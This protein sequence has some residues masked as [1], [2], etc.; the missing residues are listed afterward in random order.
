MLGKAGLATSV[1]LMASGLAHADSTI[2]LTAAPTT[3]TLPDGQT[4]PMWGLLCGSFTGS[5]FTYSAGTDGT[6]TGT[7][8]TT[9][10]GTAHTG[11]SWQP[12]RITVPAGKLSITLRNKLHSPVPTSLVIVGQVGGGLGGTPTTTPSPAHSVQGTT[13]PGTLGGTDVGAGDAVNVP[14]LQAARVQSFGTEVPSGGSNTL[15]WNNLRAGTYLIESGTHPSIQGPMG[16]YGV[17][18]VTDATYPGVTFDKDVALLLSEIDPAQNAAVDT[19]VRTPGFSETKVW[20]ARSGEC[21]DPASSTLNTCYPPAVNY[22]PRYYLINGVSFDRTR[23]AGSTIAGPGATAT[24]GNVLLRFVN[25]GL[26]MHVPSVVGA[27]MSLYAEDGNLLPGTPKIQD[28]V[29]LAAGKTYD[30]TIQP[31][32]TGTTYDSAAYAV[33]DRQLSLSTNNMRDGGMQAYISA[34]GGAPAAGVA[35]TASALDKTY[36][37]VAGRALS[38]T[39]PS[40]G[41]LGGS[42][43]ASGVSLVDSTLSPAD[44]SLSLQANGTFTYTPPAVPASCSGSFSYTV[45]GN[46]ALTKTA[47]ITECDATVQGPGCSLGGQP[48][49]AN[50]AYNNNIASRLQ[51]RAPGV[52]E[53]DTDPTGLPLCATKVGATACST[54]PQTFA[55]TNGAVTLNPDG[56]FVLTPT[57]VP[58]SGPSTVTFQYQAMNSQNRASGVATATVTFN[59]GNSIAFAVRDAKTGLAIHDYRWIIEEDRTFWIEPKCQINSTDPAVRP[60]TCPPLPVE[61]LGY[62]F[63]TANMPVVATGCLGAVSCESG[64]AIDGTAVACDVGD[65][66]CRKDASQ[67]VATLPSEVALDPNKRYYISILPGD[68]VNPVIGGAGGPDDNGKPFSIAAAC[69][70]YVEQALDASLTGSSPWTPGGANAMCGH[71]MG[72][73]QISA[74]QAGQISINLQQTP[75][76]TAKISVFVFEDDNPLNGE[77]DAGGGVDVLAPNEPGLGGFEVKLFDQA[78]GLGDATGQITY[79][80]FNMPVSNSLAGMPDPLHG[81]Q[82]ACPITKRADALVGMIPTCPHFEVDGVTESPL[83]GQALIANLYPGLYEVVAT[84]ASDRIARGEEW[85]QSN[86]LDGGKPHEAFIK[87][88]E[89]SYFQEFGPGG[90]HISIG[91]TNPKLITD[92]RSNTAGT[93]LCDPKPR[94]G[95]LTCD[96]TLKGSVTNARMSRTPDQRIYSSKSYD[97][98]S[99]TQCYVG[100]GAPDEPDFAFAKCNDDGTFEMDHLPSGDFKLTVFDQW[101]DLMLDGLVSP[102]TVASGTTVKEFPVTQWRTNLYTRTFLD[103]DGDGV[104]TRDADGNDSELGLPLVATNIRYRDGSFGF[105]N[106]TDLNG[107]A[108]FNEVFPFMNWL[109]VEAD[110]TRYKP[111]SAHVVYDTGGPADGAGGGTSAIAAGLANTIETNSLPSNLRVPGARYCASADCPAGDTAGGSSGRVDPAGITTEAW[112]GLLGQNSFIE[113]GMKPFQAGENGGIKGHVI[114]ASTRP[115]DD[116]AL[117]LQLSWEPGVPRVKL[118]LYQEGTAPDGTRTLKLVDTTTSSSWDDWAQ[119]FRSDGMPNMNCPGQAADSPFFETL[120]DS[121]QYLDPSIPKKDLPNHSQYKCYDGWSQLNQ[122]QPA[123]Y[124]GMYKFPSVTGISLVAETAG[125]PSGTNCSICVDNPSGDGTK[126]LPAGKYVVEVVLPEGF[127]LVKEEDK[128]ILLGDVYIA[129]VTQQFAGLGNIFIMPDQAAVN[130]YYNASNPGGINLTTNLGATARHEGDTGSVESFWPCV[131]AE[132]V[133]PDLNSLF[134]GAGQAAPFAGATR[135][136]CDRKEVILEDQAAVLAKFYVFTPTHIAGHFTGTITDDFASEF[137]PFSPQF[138][139]K[140]GPPNLPVGIRDFAG[141]EVARVVSD[142]W[143]L[144]NGLNYSSYAV[145]PPNPTGY[146][147]T[148]MIACMNDPGPIPVTNAQGQML[149]ASGAVVTDRSLAKMITDPSYNP[150]YS[151]FCYETPFMPGFT[152]YMDT[153]VIPTMAFADGY[154]LPDSEYPDATPAILRVDAEG[155]IGPWVGLAGPVASVTLGA[156]GSYTTVPNVTFTPTDSHGSGAAATALLG[157]GAVTV[158]SPNGTYRGIATP[159]VTF[160]LPGCAI[161]GTT[162]VRATGTATMSGGGITSNTRHVTGI[163][164]TNPGRGYTTAPGITFSTGPATAVASLGVSFVNLTSGGSGYDAVPAVTFSTGSATATA[165]LGTLTASG[166]LTITALGDKVVQNPAFSGPNS[167]TAPYNQKTIVRHYVFG[168][169]GPSSA[170]TIGGVNAPITSWSDTSITVTV[171]TTGVPSCSANGPLQRTGVGTNTYA[172]QCGELVITAAN[173]KKSID[174]VTVTLGGKPPTYVT[175]QNAGGNALQLAVDAA[176]PGDLIIVGPGTY[177]ENLLMWKPVRLQGVGAAAV[178]I[179]ADAHPAGKMDSWRRQVNCLFGLTLAGT[180]AANPGAYDASGTYTCSP[181][182][183]LRVDRIPFEGFIGWDASTNGNLAQVLQEPT[184]MGAYE[185]AGITVLGR[186]IRIPANSNDF[187]GQGLGESTFPDGSTYLNGSNTN[188]NLNNATLTNGR[189]YYTSNFSCNPSRIDGVS[190]INSSQGGGGIFVHGWNHNLEIANTRVSANHGTL[191]G[192]ITIGNGETPP[193]YL[194]DGTT[195]GNGV[196]TPAPLCPPIPNGTLTNGAI[197]FAL[198]THVHVHHNSVTNNASIGDAL[199]SGTPSGA[200]GV[201]FSAGADNYVFDHNWIAGNLSTGDG[202]GVEHSGASWNGR[203]ANNWILFNQSINPT[204]PTNGGGL[205]IVGANSDRVLPDGSECGTTTDTDCPPGIGDGTGAGLVI[206]ANLILGNSAESGS[207]GGLRLQQVNGSEVGNFPILNGQW[208]DVTVTNNVIANNV[209]GWDGGGVS[210]Q[211]ALKVTLVNNTVVSNDTTAS[212]GVLFKTLGA[213]DSSAPPPGCTPTSDPTQPQNP[214]CLVPNAPHNPQPAGL[215]TISHTPNLIDSMPGTVLCP[216]G[217]NYGNASD[218]LLSRT[219]GLCRSL[220]MPALTND[221]FWQNRAFHVDIVDAHG[222]VVTSPDPSNPT[223][224]G[225]QSQQNLVALTPQLNQTSTGQCVNGANYWDV[226]VRDDSSPTNHSG[227]ATLTLNNSILTSTG[228]VNGSGNVA[229]SASPVIAQ[230]CNGSRLPPENG[231]HGYNAPAG[232]SETTGL[233]PLFVFNSI[234]PAATVD[235]GHNWINL[236]YGPLSLSKPAASG[237]TAAEMM[238]ASATVGP[239]AGAYSISGIS[240]AV[241]KGSNGDAPSRDFFGNTRT[242]SNSDRADIGAVEFARPA[243]AL[244]VVSPA[245]LAFGDVVQGTTS[246]RTLTVSNN[247][248]TAFTISAIAVTAP[249]IRPIGTGGGTCGTTGPA[250]SVGPGAS[251]TINVTIT[252]ATAGPLSGTATITAS[253]PVNGSPVA[254]SANG[255]APT[256]TATATPNPLAFG[257]W[258]SGTTSAPQNLTITNTGNAALAGLTIGTSGIAPFS[259]VI[260][261]TFPTDAPSCAATLAVGASCTVKTQFAPTATGAVSRNVTVT[262]TG[263]T[264]TTSP[265]VLTGNGL[266]SNARATAAAAPSPLTITLLS[267]DVGIAGSMTSTGVVTLTNTAAAG[268]SQLTVT[269]IAI[270]QPFGTALQYNFGTGSTAGPDTCTGAALAP[271]SSCSLTVRFTNLIAARGPQRHGTLTFTD[272]AQGGSQSVNLIGVAAP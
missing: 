55:G 261:G 99:F 228:G 67:K 45:N 235:E 165:A 15:V 101:N 47:T 72:G 80:M 142:Q 185:G 94:G 71:A 153:P 149:D 137:D 216:A 58:T 76:P 177:K 118:N 16:L 222:N 144:Y 28:E 26:R 7:P 226:G 245:P 240:D 126:M 181:S 29:F 255:V 244:A 212:A 154:N 79:D 13:W 253:V 247:G 68:G 215:V 156:A 27:S 229:P 225:L 246:T 86:T 189:D 63:H 108:G 112:Q 205:A 148:M 206:D 40:K 198:N 262:A 140:F 14:P 191:S 124:D 100:L 25:A 241:N 184:L 163:N 2:T 113:F 83:A 9:L 159:N 169:Q 84:P 91:F 238:L 59:P 38:V 102:V 227:G 190:V 103:A 214:N 150:A 44:A 176:R 87:P 265:V 93:G 155:G 233:S 210:L 207:G 60:S 263:A 98:Y 257:N 158:N 146:V 192:G 65:G 128:N 132:R 242:L 17:V 136:L 125:K 120:K 237:S 3:T 234:T 39:D 202:G 135:H 54:Q 53:N 203:I 50:D 96:A 31:S 131:G 219:N 221:M 34:N 268:G 73:A 114:Y 23:L 217:F 66:A 51:I 218:G 81:N 220:S 42:S 11:N 168:A 194:N 254:L 151:N 213:I 121:K 252:P 201:T 269:G 196:A 152:A 248:G 232:R 145:N 188:C 70:P 161:N 6:P 62:S 82:D 199:F 179:N 30:V 249:F 187:W 160:A 74:G 111:T 110:T 21:G 61:S 97:S 178:T 24:T 109:V 117:S 134:P 175:G 239:V 166:S 183:Y 264:I 49:A 122:V 230:Y 5:A 105:F 260:S 12:P 77:N 143:G 52:L 129:P 272:T 119:G 69:G 85:L 37:C 267:P 89:P 251:C 88:D 133:V 127:E 20:S 36:Y 271:G 139:E 204:L 95:G 258:A 92:R 32:K 223:G 48:V 141:T 104:S 64:Q 130:A 167:K 46:A 266:A 19:A 22:D 147:P 157:V 211:D 173:G 243:T 170:V 200:G 270:T 172:A 78:G 182:M 1:L 8:C 10:A 180:P 162:C 56:S 106:N 43:S 236:T 57:S 116:P 35:A 193:T 107:Y 138:G 250:A 174:T 224:G 115:F 259:R 41:L 195:C 90:F 209:A 18:V 197:P 171:P 208:Y 123:P 186:G 33:Y 231:G 256:R 4:V 164:I 75:L